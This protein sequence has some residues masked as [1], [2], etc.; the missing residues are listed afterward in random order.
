MGRSADIV[1]CTVCETVKWKRFSRSNTEA[2]GM[3]SSQ[4]APK[5]ISRAEFDKLF[6]ELSNWGRWGADDE[7][8]TLNYILPEHVRAAAALVR[9]GRSVSLSLPINT[10]AGP[11]NSRPA[12]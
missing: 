7:R 11:D 6:Q 2:D 10:V 4:T 3:S 1:R 8:G 12:V 9:A 5:R